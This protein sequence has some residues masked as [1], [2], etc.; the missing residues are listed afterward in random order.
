MSNPAP[1][2]F[3]PEVFDDIPINDTWD[4][5][6]IADRANAHLEA[7]MSKWTKVYGTFPGT[8]YWGIKFDKKDDTYFSYL[9]PPQLIEPEDCKH[10]AIEYHDEDGVKVFNA[11]CEKCG[12]PLVPTWTPVKKDGANE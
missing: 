5:S 12:E 3:T 7:E 10:K 1:F 4:T 9:T 6:I 8:G 2:K 11:M